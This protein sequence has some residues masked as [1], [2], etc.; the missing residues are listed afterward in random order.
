MIDRETPFCFRFQFTRQFCFG[1]SAPF[2]ELEIEGAA[3]SMLLRQ[4]M[5]FSKYAFFTAFM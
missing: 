2:V 4:V 3:F 1:E 5:E